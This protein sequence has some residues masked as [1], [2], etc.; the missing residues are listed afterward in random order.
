M[1]SRPLALALL[2][3]AGPALADVKENVAELA[4]WL[5]EHSG[6]TPNTA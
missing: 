2:L 5:K 1:W 4:A 6:E 3:L